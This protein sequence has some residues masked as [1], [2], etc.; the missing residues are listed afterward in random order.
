MRLQ[1]ME[2]KDKLLTK[3]LKS[4][5]TNKPAPVDSTYLYYFTSE[6]KN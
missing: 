2:L 1:L 6:I 3:D 4:L 5:F